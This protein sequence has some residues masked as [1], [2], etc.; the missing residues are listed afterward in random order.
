MNDP[1]VGGILRR[2]RGRKGVSDDLLLH[3]RPPRDPRPINS[4]IHCNPPF[5]PSIPP[6]PPLNPLTR[7]NS[8][9][10]RGRTPLCSVGNCASKH[11]QSSEILTTGG[12]ISGEG[13]HR[14]VLCHPD[15]I[16]LANT[17]SLSIK[18]A[19]HCC[20]SFWKVV[21]KQNR[22]AVTKI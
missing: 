11:R 4:P 13:K 8:I 6:L 5:P 20:G 12:Y 19:F 10:R 9:G 15:Y 7:S 18:F 17:R 21:G 22:G 2:M 14:A 1:S 3:Q 16:G